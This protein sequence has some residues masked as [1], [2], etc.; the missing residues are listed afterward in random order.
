MGSGRWRAG[1]A[2]PSTSTST[3]SSGDFDE[4]W[5]SRVRERDQRARREAPDPGSR[6]APDRV[7]RD[8]GRGP[9]RLLLPR[10]GCPERGERRREAARRGRRWGRRPPERSERRELLGA[11]LLLHG[12]ATPDPTDRE[13]ER[14]TQ[15]AADDPSVLLPVPVRDEDGRG[16]NLR[17]HAE[18]RPCGDN[19]RGRKV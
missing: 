1:S 14:E 9:V 16:P 4:D 15:R 11:D 19:L 13:G 2:A 7:P 5:G 12:E 8:R 18:V 10:R 6:G 3:G 17:G